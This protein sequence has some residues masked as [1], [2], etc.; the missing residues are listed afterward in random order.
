MRQD[1]LN[2]QEWKQL[3]S[4]LG[5]VLARK[6]FLTPQAAHNA[7]SRYAACLD[8]LWACGMHP[9][10]LADPKRH[11]LTLKQQYGG[12]V[13]SWKRPKTLNWCLMPVSEDLARELENYA[14]EPYSRKTIWEMVR[15]CSREAGLGEVGP[16]TIRHT[17]AAQLV[18]TLGPSVAKESLA[19]GDRALQHYTALTA[20]TRLRAIR[21]SRQNTSPVK[22]PSST[23]DGET[24]GS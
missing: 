19:V 15:Q 18:R 9:S 6:S 20:G 23:E 4:A 7:H 16:L 13:A 22:T 12:W 3:R 8:A 17:V 14:S 2:E 5:A 10:V 21:E 1:P 24:N 11:N